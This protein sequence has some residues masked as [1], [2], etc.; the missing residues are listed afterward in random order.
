[1]A[2]RDFYAY[3][4][5]VARTTSGRERRAGV[6]GGEPSTA[7]LRASREDRGRLPADA[8]AAELVAEREEARLRKR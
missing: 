8:T 2:R 1:V 3:R 5:A 4:Q 6:R 7:W